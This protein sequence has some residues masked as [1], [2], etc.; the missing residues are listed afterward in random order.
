[1]TALKIVEIPEWYDGPDVFVAEDES[2]VLY[3]AH[4]ISPPWA[5][6]RHQGVKVDRQQVQRLYDGWIGLRELLVEAGEREWWLCEA[7]GAETRLITQGS[8]ISESGFLPEPGLVM[9]G[10]WNSHTLLAPGA[11]TLGLDSPIS[12]SGA[13]QSAA[14]G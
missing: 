2:G 3:L 11:R 4:R 12:G 10:P 7:E 6:A 1:M 5:P 13:A 14:S 9:E 8:C